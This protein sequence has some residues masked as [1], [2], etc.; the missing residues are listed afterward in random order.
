[1]DRI[2][3]DSFYESEKDAS[4]PSWEAAVWPWF[5]LP[6]LYQCSLWFLAVVLHP[7]YEC[8][9]TI[10]AFSNFIDLYIGRRDAHP[11]RPFF[12][13]LFGFVQ[14]FASL[15]E[16]AIFILQTGS[17]LGMDKHMIDV[18]ERGLGIVIFAH[19]FLLMTKNEFHVSHQILSRSNLVDLMTVPQMILPARCSWMTC[20]YLRAFRALWTYERMASLH[21]AGAIIHLPNSG[22]TRF[23][24]TTLLRFLAMLVGFAGLVFTLE[25]LGDPPWMQAA[26]YQPTSMGEMSFYTMVY[27]VV[28]T[29][30]TVGYGDFTP[31]TT[32]SRSAAMFCM[33]SGVLFFTT[34]ATKFAEMVSANERGTSNYEKK[35]RNHV[36]LLGSGVNRLDKGILKAFFSELYHTEYEDLW[37]DCVILCCSQKSVHDMHHFKDMVVEPL[38]KGR[39]DDW[40]TVLLGSP[41]EHADL[42][43]CRCESADLIIV[44]ADT[45]KNSDEDADLQD[46]QN[47]LRALSICSSYPAAPLRLALLSADSRALAIHA[48][49]QPQRCFAI[50][51]VGALLFWQSC[52]CIG[53][54]TLVSNLVVTTGKREVDEIRR[55]RRIGDHKEAPSRWREEYTNGM[56]HEVYGFLPCKRLCGR[57]FRELV[58]EAY[59]E[60]SIIVFAIQREGE[61]KIAP[62][63]D[64]ME[65][66]H[67]TVLFALATD[68]SALRNFRSDKGPDWRALFYKNRYSMYA[69]YR[70]TTK[71]AN[72]SLNLRGLP[73]KSEIMP[74]NNSRDS[75]AGEPLLLDHS[76][77]LQTKASTVRFDLRTSQEVPASEAEHDAGTISRAHSRYSLVAAMARVTETLR[78]DDQTRNQEALSVQHVGVLSQHAQ[79]IR[80]NHQHSNFIVFVELCKSWRRVALFLKESRK[81][82]LPQHTPIIILHPS[83]PP[84]E[85]IQDLGLMND[86]TIGAVIG[87]YES[88]S[89]LVKAGILEAQVIV[90]PAPTQI[91]GSTSDMLDVESPSMVDA[92]SVLL[93]KMLEG[94]DVS[95]HAMTLFEFNQIDNVR[96][97]S[98]G[99]EDNQF[100]EAESEMLSEEIPMMKTLTHRYERPKDIGRCQSAMKAVSDM[101]KAPRKL[102]NALLAEAPY[103]P[104]FGGTLCGNSKFVSGEVFSPIAMGSM[105]ANAFYTP[106]I[107]EVVQALV[108]P[109]ADRDTFIWQIHACPE[110]MVGHTFSRCWQD[111]LSADRGGPA[112]ALG[113][114]RFVEDCD[115]EAD[116]YDFPPGYVV[117]NPC[118]DDKVRSTDLIYVLASSAWGAFMHDEMLLIQ[119]RFDQGHLISGI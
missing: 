46:K 4:Q 44:L 55:G 82:W 92:Q 35:H 2:F 95:K 94:L 48:G 57:S 118:Q 88:V 38:L 42:N 83:A 11:R 105:L 97:L 73:S 13:T 90:C 80:D 50:D 89:D 34:Q 3:D 28:E 93:Y 104:T 21:D 26:F 100:S 7:L 5:I 86:A 112:L 12:I 67:D 76:D 72:G 117:L 47:I 43:R 96:L 54:S 14:L 53:L 62:L 30:T 79:Q 70:R 114:Y 52:R 23:K 81:S 25:V 109:S 91:V 84:S 10:N 60:E 51:E 74:R 107:M 1:M 56:A 106:G 66:T 78:H 31:K 40:L 27:W 110:T 111:L 6:V 45:V 116:E 19:M 16:V 15:G 17:A 68:A 77:T 71:K 108:A 85:I 113:V 32:S 98:K 65:I 41:L 20:G 61:I 24:I 29:I 69:R 87:S 8:L 59:L 101:C 9:L 18:I 115:L 63:M 99:E 37:P 103:I 22:L 75:D 36:V 39:A 64:Q 33:M 49:I 119:A 102:K 58:E